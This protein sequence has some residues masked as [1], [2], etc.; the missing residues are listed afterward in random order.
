MRDILRGHVDAVK[1][2][3]K[4]ALLEDFYESVRHYSRNRHLHDGGSSGKMA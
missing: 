1:A 2:K 4:E 3:L